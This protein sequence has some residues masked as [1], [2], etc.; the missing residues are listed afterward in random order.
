MSKQRFPV[1]ISII[2]GENKASDRCRYIIQS[3]STAGCARFVNY[4]FY[5]SYSDYLLS[6]RTEVEIPRHT[7]RI[8]AKTAR[9]LIFIAPYVNCLRLWRNGAAENDLL[10]HKLFPYE[11]LESKFDLAIKNVKVSPRSSLEHF[12][13][14]IFKTFNEILFFKIFP[15]LILPK[16]KSRSTQGH[17]VNYL[18]ITLVPNATY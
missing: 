14:K 6:G 15:C 7:E 18:G 3:E 11:S 4:Q 9:R 13:G 17:Y 5:S 2:T 10:F 16:N 12:W 1:K 8:W